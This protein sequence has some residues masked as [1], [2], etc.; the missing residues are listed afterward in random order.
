[1]HSRTFAT[2]IVVELRSKTTG[3]GSPYNELVGVLVV[4]DSRSGVQHGESMIRLRIRWRNA[5]GV[6]L[7]RCSCDLSLM[8]K[9]YACPQCPLVSP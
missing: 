7:H 9:A 4:Y 5:E 3:F 2:L 8:Y 6:N 1:M